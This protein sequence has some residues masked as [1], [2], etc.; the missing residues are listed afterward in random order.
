MR[1]TFWVV[2]GFLL[3]VAAAAQTPT[4]APPTPPAYAEMIQVTAT[5][6]PEDVDVVP[7]SIQVISADELR[8]R[9]ATDL[10]SA[11]ALVSGVLIAPGGDGGPAGAV[12]Q[13]WGL[14]EQ[15]AYLLVV[16]GVPWGGAFNPAVSTLDLKDVERIEVQHG[17]AP[18]MYGATSFVGVIQVVRRAPGAK[19]TRIAA[20]GG[21]YE[22][23]GGA[24]STRVPTWLGF[25]SSLGADFQRE[26]F[27]DDRTSFKKGHVLWRNQRVSGPG[28][29]RFDLDA[30]FLRQE[31]ASPSP[32][33]GSSL[34][35]LVPI[36]SNQ[37]PA[38]AF[39]NQ[40][41]YFV[42]LGYD[43]KLSF[44]S[45]STSA[46]Y[47]HSS[48]DV[49]RGFLVDV[50]ENDPNAH[51]FRQTIDGD[52][53]Y[54]DTHLSW[55]GSARWKAVAGIDY[56][57][58]NGKAQG[59]DFD[60]F[61]NLDGSNPPTSTELPPAADIHVQDR[62]NF[63]GLYGQVEWLPS[64]AWR[65]EAGARLNVTGESRTTSTLDFES[66]DLTG[67]SDD[68]TTVRPSG[69]LGLTWTAWKRGTN[70]LWAF[71]NWRNTFKP[72]AVDFGLD[73]ESEILKPETANSYEAGLKSE[74]LGRAL[75]L[76][77]A[78]Y[79]MDFSNLVVAQ[80]IEGLPALANA[81]STRFKG[82]E[83]SASWQI[84]T[85]LFARGSYAWQ[86]ARFQDYL[87]EF[88]GVPTQLGGN[89]IEMSPHEL[90]ALALS[91][92]PP[93]GLFASGELSAV[94]SRYLNKRNTALAGAYATLGAL[95]GWRN[96]RLEVRLSGRNLTD[97]RD[98]VSESELGDAQYYRLFPRRVDLTATV[99]F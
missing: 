20:S 75:R 84:V 36:D 37:N 91:W 10:Q 4:P 47:T 31:P 18:V 72:S 1:S 74:L 53:L 24:L 40:D 59:G 34:S 97:R 85:G 27:E 89:R 76:E 35:P 14:Q 32:R 82:V 50:S 46:A 28:V 62:R 25:D 29:F 22:S 43:R 38:G 94:G 80:A 58:G 78:G 99:S 69:S 3:P 98:P 42:N 8:Q 23:G 65:I 88:D 17:P 39:L 71:A 51:G 7:T 11:L 96:E 86:D 30:V 56:L 77:V 67:G 44:G 66:G 60:Y 87:T 68:V 54:L 61:V 41:R 13:F 92:S 6:I 83:L 93:R 55:T 90:G 21:S 16:D 79:F 49:F 95:M 45:W 48:Q 33:T 5:R 52:D 57:Y 26:G 73:S 81:G 64:P 9:G 12:P 2:A 63:G 19:G 15:D 70:A